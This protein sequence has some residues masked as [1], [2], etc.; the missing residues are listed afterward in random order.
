MFLKN[1]VNYSL[2]MQN[3]IVKV[4]L[5]LYILKHVF[6]TVFWLSN[7]WNKLCWA[8]MPGPQIKIYRFSPYRWALHLHNAWN[9]FVKFCMSADVFLDPL[10]RSEGWVNGCAPD[11]VTIN[12]SRHSHRY[13]YKNKAGQKWASKLMVQLPLLPTNS[14]NPRAQWERKNT[15]LVE[16]QGHKAASV[17][18]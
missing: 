11:N 1:N 17:L 16:K 8:H 5:A 10:A 18:I 4:L 14:L 9:T 2:C 15:L 6:C 12:I 7:E 13:S 3:T